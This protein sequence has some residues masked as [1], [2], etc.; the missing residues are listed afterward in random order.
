[1]DRV[2]ESAVRER[3]GGLCE[4]CRLA[5]E[6]SPLKYSVDHIVARQHGGATVF[7]NLALSCRSCNLHKGPNIAGIDPDSG[8][9]CRLYHP[10]TDVWAEHFYRN[11]LVI[12]GRTDIGRTTA[13]VLSMN[14]SQQLMIRRAVDVA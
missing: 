5:Q 12:L 1:M 9:M 10:R 4:Y 7:V 14:S 8:F 2:L 11:G 3:A 13:A 6:F